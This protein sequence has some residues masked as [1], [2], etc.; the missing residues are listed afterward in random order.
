MKKVPSAQELIW[1]AINDTK[2]VLETLKDERV[3]KRAEIVSFSSKNFETFFM[4]V[5]WFLHFKFNLAVSL[6]KRNAQ[7]LSLIHI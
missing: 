4:R 3:K 5:V 6:L 2:T 7:Y 1:P